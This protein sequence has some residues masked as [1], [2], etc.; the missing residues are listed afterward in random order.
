MAKTLRKP[1]SLVSVSAGKE[2]I[3]LFLS[4]ATASKAERTFLKL[5]KSSHSKFTFYPNAN[6]GIRVGRMEHTRVSKNIA[7][8]STKTLLRISL[9]RSNFGTFGLRENTYITVLLR[10]LMFRYQQNAA[11]N[12]QLS[13][14][15]VLSCVQR[16]S[17][18]FTYH[19]TLLSLSFDSSFYC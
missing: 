11:Q 12:V 19:I 9:A 13:R 10:Y 1:K 8:F 18:C 17:S 4:D 6:K 7:A 14:Q 5:Y 2:P 15:R 16:Y 3:V